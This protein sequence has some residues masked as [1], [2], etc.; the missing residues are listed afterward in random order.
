MLLWDSF[1]SSG[2]LHLSF[3]CTSIVVVLRN[4]FYH[5]Y[6]YYL[7][8]RHTIRCSFSTVSNFFFYLFHFIHFAILKFICLHYIYIYLFLIFVLSTFYLNIGRGCEAPHK[9]QHNYDDICLDLFVADCYLNFCIMLL[10]AGRILF[11]WNLS[12]SRTVLLK[13]DASCQIEYTLKKL[14]MKRRLR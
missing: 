4:I 7:K 9:C 1:R 11:L 6:S 5:K 10:S 2:M 14:N 3:T 12:I 8:Y 13:S